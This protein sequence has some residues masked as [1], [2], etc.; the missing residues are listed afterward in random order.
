MTDGYEAVLFDLYGT[1]VD[2]WTD[3][4]DPAL[5]RKMAAYYSRWGRPCA[6]AALRQAYRT[7]CARREAA[8]NR[9]LALDHKEGPGEI[10]VIPVFRT[11]A[12]RQGGFLPKAE[13]EA[14]AAWFRGLS[15]KRLLLYPGAAEVLKGLR[16]R[17][18]RV[19]LLSN[20]QAAFTRPELKR[21]C[22]D[23]LFV[24]V[25]LSSDAGVR[26]PSPAFFRLAERDGIDLRRSLMVGNDPECDCR[27]AARVGMDSLY[28]HTAQSPR[29][30]KKDLPENCREIRSLPEVL[31]WA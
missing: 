12:A 14:L 16:A 17:G 9:E 1:L 28:I 19:I 25:Y 2:I 18:K 31:T 30:S 26:K 15:L 11:L 21:L 13:A 10:D 23:R 8:L 20:A 27:G 5:W 4:E 7:L 3:E 6:P 24:R 22:I 29:G